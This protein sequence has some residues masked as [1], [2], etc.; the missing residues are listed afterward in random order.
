[1]KLISES[2]KE[3]LEPAIL[4]YGEKRNF[5]VNKPIRSQIVQ[6]LNALT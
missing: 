6:N 3:S 4:E 2:L 1:M 5:M